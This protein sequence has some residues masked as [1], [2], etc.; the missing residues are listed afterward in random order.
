[1][2]CFQAELDALL[3]PLLAREGWLPMALQRL[4][5][6]PLAR[7]IESAARPACARAARTA[8][9]AMALRARLGPWRTAEEALRA[10][11]VSVRDSGAEPVSG[12]FIHHALYTAPPPHVTVFTK[13]LEAAE[14][15][16]QSTEQRGRLG[17]VILREVVLA[18][19]LFHHLVLRLGAT[20]A[21]HP[22]VELTRLGPWRRWGVVKA[23]EEIAAAG[24]AASWCGVA[25]APEVLDCLTLAAYG[26]KSAGSRPLTPTS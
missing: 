10:Q 9:E 3:G 12:P 4:E 7:Y 22:R 11:G 20:A 5:Q 6:D 19:E 14:W 1:M 24:F 8:G 25:W 2:I 26:S 17:S 23:A 21:V 15:L 13:P 18:H 16:L